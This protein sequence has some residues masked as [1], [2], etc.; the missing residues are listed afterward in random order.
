LDV[1][2]TDLVLVLPWLTY[3]I[4][5]VR[6]RQQYGTHKRLMVGLGIVLGVAVLA[7]EVELRLVGWRQFARPSPYFETTL[8]PFLY[9]H[10]TLAIGTTVLW[11]V[12]LATALSRFP[13]PPMPSTHSRFHRRIA[14]A[15]AIGTF[16]TAITGWTFYYMA[17]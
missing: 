5:Q 9:F 8:F 4:F 6:H 3:A 7:F 10:V 1:I 15:T 16:A 13:R 11:I 14:R 12:T 17:F 2:A